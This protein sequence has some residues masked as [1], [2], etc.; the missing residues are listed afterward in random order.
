MA[1]ESLNPA[2]GER[3]ATFPETPA[4]EVDRI[5]EAAVKAQRAWARQPFAARAAPMRKVAALLKERAQDLARLA[6][7]EMGKPVKDGVGEVNKCAWVCEHNAEHAERYLTPREET[8]DGSRAYVRFD[9]LGVVLAVM[10]WNFPFWQVFRFIAP[11]LMAGNGGILKHAS[12]VPQCALAIEKA[13]HDAGFPKELFR[14]VLV[15]SKAIRP[16][17]NDPRIAAVT[18]TGSEPAGRDVAEA[19]GRAL[20]PSVME[21]GGSDPYI[22]L[23]DADL[24]EAAKVGSLARVMNA[25]QS[26]I[27]A[28]RFIV[29]KPVHDAFVAKLKASLEKVRMGDPLD[30]SSDIGPQARRE[31]RD[32]LH[33]Q[34][35]LAIQ[36]GARPLLG[37]TL[38]EGKGA[39]Y[40]P[41][42]L[43]DVRPDNVAAKEEIF[44]P[45]A[46]V[47]IAASADEAIQLANASRFGLGAALW[48]RDPAKIE[49]Y[50]P[51]IEAGAVFVNG[52][53]K[54]DP[55]LPF[56]GVKASGFGRELGL[57]GIRS[58]T[59]VKTVWIK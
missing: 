37:C 8:S 30:P 13:M 42:L 7:L 36:Q 22:V 1:I 55:R 26:C 27:C 52:L 54:S 46:A 48:T 57:E 40:P 18:I 2:T 20:K 23:A 39:F 35:K 50:V 38:P 49:R 21:L 43:D 4:A 58:F 34:V 6:A 11:H 3:L 45:V 12:N 14:T 25:G 16:L 29:E 5:V 24:D 32:E 47:M 56:G 44:G 19:A 28:K 33:G 10:P 41:S 9:P 17:I 59:N 15:G 51:L 31:L 53:V